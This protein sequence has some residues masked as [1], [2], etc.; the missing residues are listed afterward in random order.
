MGR[1]LADCCTAAAAKAAVH[2]HVGGGWQIVA[3]VFL[4]AA[5]GQSFALAVASK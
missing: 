5:G 2:F 3:G 1:L 4:L